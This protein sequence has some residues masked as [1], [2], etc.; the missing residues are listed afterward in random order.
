MLTDP[1]FTKRV[2]AM[3]AWRKVL[4]I[5]TVILGIPGVPL[6]FYL[7]L[8]TDGLVSVSLVVLALAWCFLIGFFLSSRIL[9]PSH[10]K[11][12]A[13]F[14]AAVFHTVAMVALGL[15][16]WLLWEN[17]D[18][19]RDIFFIMLPLPL[20]AG[21]VIVL[22]TAQGLFQLRCLQVLEEEAAR[23]EI[24]RELAGADV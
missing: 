17:G 18:Q 5:C 20:Y 9:P 10:M 15:F 16:A 22:S 11:V 4:S 2:R 6:T 21:G 13:W 14:F 1:A 24:R 19:V 7:S 12:V 23:E 3:E 8:S